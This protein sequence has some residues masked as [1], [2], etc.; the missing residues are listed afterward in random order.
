MANY[1]VV[2]TWPFGQIAVKAAAPLL[3][4]GKPALDAAIA[5]AQAVE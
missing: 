2:A 4:Q 3:Q 5:G 1:I